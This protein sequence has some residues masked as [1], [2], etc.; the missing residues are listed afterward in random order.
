MTA[1]DPRRYTETLSLDIS[2]NATIDVQ[3]EPGMNNEDYV[4]DQIR[5]MIQADE[6]NLHY[7]N[8]LEWED[9]L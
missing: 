2:L 6:S 5:S 1:P 9:F 7:L 8:N 3:L 4:R